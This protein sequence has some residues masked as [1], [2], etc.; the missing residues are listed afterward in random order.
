MKYTAVKFMATGLL[1][2]LMSSA[3]YAQD[4]DRGDELRERRRDGD[5]D[6]A[7]PQRAPAGMLGDLLAEGGQ[8]D[9]GG[10]D[11]DRAGEEYGQRY[12]EAIHVR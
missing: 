9:A 11:D 3:T 4:T 8:C 10:H 5:E 6:R 7:D 12:C 2:L 1:I